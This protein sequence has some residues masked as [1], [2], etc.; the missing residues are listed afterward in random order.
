MAL[1]LNY[2]GGAG[3]SNFF[4]YASAQLAAGGAAPA[5]FAPVQAQ[6]NTIQAEI[7]EI[8]ARGRIVSLLVFAG[9]IKLIGPP[10]TDNKTRQ[11]GTIS[12]FLE[13]PFASTAPNDAIKYPTTLSPVS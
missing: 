9:G 3:S 11:D 6:I 10:Q 8:N 2:A 4:P 1:L 5:W 7:R 12:P 13:I